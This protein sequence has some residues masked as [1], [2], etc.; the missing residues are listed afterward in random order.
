LIEVEKYWEERISQL[1]E[2]VVGGGDRE[3]VNGD[4]YNNNGVGNIRRDS[5]EVVDES[6]EDDGGYIV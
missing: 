3:N 4:V 1:M 6:N 5:K 2:I